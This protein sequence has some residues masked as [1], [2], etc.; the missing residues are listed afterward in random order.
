MTDP[1]YAKLASLLV[2]YSVELKKNERILLDMIDVPDEFAIQMMRAV[3]QV[4]AIPLIETRHTRISR[5]VMR[6]TNDAHAS[7]VRD[8]EMFRMKKRAGLHRHARHRQC[9]RNRPTCRATGWRFIPRPCGR[10]RI[11]ALTRRAGASCAGPARAWPRPP[12]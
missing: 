8:V 2:K 11:I 7:L 3:R 4:G 10:C 9:Q 5:E 6:Q 12:T 1:R